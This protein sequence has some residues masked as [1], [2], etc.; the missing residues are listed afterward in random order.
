MRWK[1]WRKEE[2]RGRRGMMGIR[3]RG[4]GKERDER[5]KE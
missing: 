1:G 3:N 5:N 4:R 2:K